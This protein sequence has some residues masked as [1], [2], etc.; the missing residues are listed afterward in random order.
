MKFMMHG[1]VTIDTLDGANIEISDEVGNNNIFIFGLTARQVLS[2]IVTIA[3]LDGANIEI[4]DEVG[5][6]NIF[7][8]GLTARQVLSYIENGGYSSQDIYNKNESIKNVIDDLING[9][10]SKDREKF[11]SIYDHL[12]IFNDEFYVLKDFDSYVETNK[13]VDSIFKDM[14]KWQEICGINIAHSMYKWQEICGANIAHSGVFSS[15]RTIQQYAT[16]IWGP[17]L[18]YKN[19]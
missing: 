15:D 7:I 14:Y 11:R 4:S 5:N 8:F 13:K 9:K 18:I 6:N 19:L 3:T 16:G 1:A 12:T 17:E 10:Y 2:Y